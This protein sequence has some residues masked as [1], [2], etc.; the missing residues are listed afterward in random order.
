MSSIIHIYGMLRIVFKQNQTQ[1]K[2]VPHSPKKLPTL[3][4]NK[5]CED[6]M[7]HQL[8]WTL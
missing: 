7:K 3:S 8:Q 6:F 2:Y 4:K 5:S 1:K